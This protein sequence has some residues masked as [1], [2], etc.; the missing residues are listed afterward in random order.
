[1]FYIDN[2]LGRRI[3]KSDLLNEV[4]HFF[5]TRD[6]CIFSK[7]EDMSCNKDIVEKFIGCKMST[8]QP[9]HGVN[10]EKIIKNKY[11]YLKTDGLLLDNKNSSA[12]M[13][14][15]DCTPL[16]FYCNKV[17]MI[18]HAGWQGTVG[19]MAKV[20]VKKLVDE[21]GFNPKNIKVVIGP[22]IC[23]NCYE[24][25]DDV[26]NALFKTVK[27]HDKLFFNNNGRLYVDL[28]NINKQQ[29]I[30]CGVEQI[31]VCPYCTACGEKLFYSYRHENHTGYRHSV[32]V[33]L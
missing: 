17:V 28:K 24:V 1:M 9:V 5:T 29:L 14:F 26:Y 15:G 6:I 4:E 2:I 25:G 19:E 21:Y 20:S 7:D 27:H 30:E 18:S 16:I 12:Y 13:N 31:D 3:V 22:T 33:K 11:F 8:C 23:E 32:V 10:I